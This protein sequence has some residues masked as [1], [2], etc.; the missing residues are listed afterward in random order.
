MLIKK[1]IFFIIFY[2]ASFIY[3][4]EVFLYDPVKDDIELLDV[5]NYEQVVFNSTKATILEFFA[6]WCGTCQRFAPRK[7]KYF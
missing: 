6:H 7:H 1:L 5:S 3:C 4:K 2:S